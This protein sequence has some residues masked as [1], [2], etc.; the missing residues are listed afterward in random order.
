MN[1]FV[2]RIYIVKKYICFIGELE[3]FIF[4][5][6]RNYFKNMM[7]MYMKDLIF[8]VLY[9]YICYYEIFL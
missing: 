7:Y 3:L 1:I 8:F 6:C 2:N 9:F 5:V 4:N